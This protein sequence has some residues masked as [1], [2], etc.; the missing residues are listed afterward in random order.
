M[1]TIP[2]GEANLR[3]IE[4]VDQ[5]QP[6]E[7]HRVDTRQRYC[8]VVSEKYHSKAGTPVRPWKG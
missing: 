8:C 4:L 3:L 2:I 1:T 5:L 7:G 6:G